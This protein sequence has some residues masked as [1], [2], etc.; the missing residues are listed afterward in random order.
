MHVITVDQE[1]PD[2]MAMRVLIETSAS[3]PRSTR[4]H[5]WI[6]EHCLILGWLCK[7]AWR[8]MPRESE[9]KGLHALP[10]MRL[11]HGSVAAQQE[12][13]CGETP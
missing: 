9:L 10:G 13:T 7:A 11:V 8:R 6:E 3:F 12:G 1:R 5:P 4:S 2:P